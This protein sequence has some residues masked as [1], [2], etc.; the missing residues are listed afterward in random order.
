[1]GCVSKTSRP[2]RQ[3]RVVLFS[4]ADRKVVQAVSETEKSEY[5]LTGDDFEGLGPAIEDLVVHF[6][7][8]N[9]TVNDKLQ[10]EV[11]LQKRFV[12]AN[13][14]DGGTLL[15]ATSDPEYAISLPFANRGAFGVHSRIVL[16]AFLASGGAVG[17]AGEVSVV[18]A[19]RFFE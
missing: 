19:V 14:V 16:R 7:G 17:R 3:S 15:S 1:M 4:L 10:V 8:N 18:V 12:G 2:V 11:V 13:W 9:Y 6:E 5:V